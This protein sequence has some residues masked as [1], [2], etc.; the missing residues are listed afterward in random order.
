MIPSLLPISTPEKRYENRSIKITSALGMAGRALRRDVCWIPD[1]PGLYLS[2]SVEPRRVWVR[3]LVIHVIPRRLGEAL[4]LWN[5]LPGTNLLVRNAKRLTRRAIWIGTI[6]R[7]SVFFC[8]GVWC[9][10]NW[11]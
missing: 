2:A 5:G 8:N 3:L 10:R 6:W 7:P 1:W 11:P 4:G 9:D